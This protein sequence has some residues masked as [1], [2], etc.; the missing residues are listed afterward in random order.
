MYIIFKHITSHIIMPNVI[1]LNFLNTK[2]NVIISHPPVGA[3]MSET[4]STTILYITCYVELFP[5]LGSSA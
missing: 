5:T 2:S 1:L 3:H 4:D